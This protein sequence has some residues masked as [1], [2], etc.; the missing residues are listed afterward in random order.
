MEPSSKPTEPRARPPDG[1]NPHHPHPPTGGDPAGESAPQAARAEGAR[2]ELQEILSCLASPQRLAVLALLARGP[3][4]GQQIAATL[5]MGVALLD[6]HLRQLA[7]CA[8]VAAGPD[9]TVYS[10]RPAVDVHEVHGDLHINIRAA[11]GSKVQAQLPM[12]T[13]TGR[14]LAR[15]WGR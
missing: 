9:R 10:L 3:A 15:A 2:G 14:M 6:D 11:D 4:T 12:N 1:N 5:N 7:A 8:L 13:P